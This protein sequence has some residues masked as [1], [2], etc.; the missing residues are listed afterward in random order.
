MK[1]KKNV[2]LLTAIFL[3]VISIILLLFPI[4][5]ITNLKWSL[6]GIMILYSVSNLI[7]FIL[8]R[9]AKDYEGIAISIC[10]LTIGLVG[11]MFKLY[12]TPIKVAITLL[13][14]VALM[15]LIKLKKADYYH[16][17]NSSLWKISMATLVIFVLIGILTS[18]NLYHAEDIQTII[19]GFFFFI[20]GLLE[21]M[22]PV[23]IHF[24]GVK[25]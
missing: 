21:L 7:Q 16:D 20:H 18:F 17:Q 8:T 12:Q 2:D 15:S 9:K 13:T 23:A 19:L 10:S 14:W 3:I 6:F 25:K 4:L 24:L 22:E 1:N 11:L 5:K